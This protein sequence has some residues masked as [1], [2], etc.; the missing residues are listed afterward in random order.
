MP[1][2]LKQNDLPDN[3]AENVPL[4]LAPLFASALGLRRLYWP[5]LIR[6]TE[7]GRLRFKIA[8][9]STKCPEILEKL[10]AHATTRELTEHLIRAD[11]EK[12]LW[13]NQLLDMLDDAQWKQIYPIL[14]EFCGSDMHDETEVMDTTYYIRDMTR[15]LLEFILYRKTTAKPY[16]LRAVKRTLP[17]YYIDNILVLFGEKPT[18]I[19]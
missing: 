14:L 4:H 6:L 2:L 7:S 17:Q 11:T 5:I 18:K 13:W 12:L 10:I 1:G 15:T 3:I 19:T 8:H 9:E 16:I